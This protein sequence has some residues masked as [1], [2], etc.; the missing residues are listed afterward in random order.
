MITRPPTS[1]RLHD[2]TH[3]FKY[4][5]A[6][7]AKIILANRTL[8]WS[9]PIHF[10]DIFDV[11]REVAPNIP[12]ESISQ[13]VTNSLFCMIEQSGL[14]TSLSEQQRQQFRHDFDDEV[15]HCPTELQSLDVTLAILRQQWREAIPAMRI[16]C[17]C[18]RNDIPTMWAH[19]TDQHRGVVLRFE[20]SEFHD[21]PWLLARPVKYSPSLPAFATA[22]GFAAR[23]LDGPRALFEDY[24]YLKT[25]DWAYECEW[26]VVC[27][28]CRD[29]HGTAS[30][31]GFAPSSLSEV[32]LGPRISHEDA[33][34]ITAF[35]CHD[36]NHVRAIQAKP[37]PG[38]QLTFDVI[39]RTTKGNPL[40]LSVMHQ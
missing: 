1:N 17:L 13:V 23:M 35:L 2:R 11:H 22:E 29:D 15:R 30:D 33:H 4:V 18:E 3:F 26:R 39:S 25:P 28:A 31:W 12:A 10:N 32:I 16:L 5:T 40:D 8:R 20:C 14:L 19:Y 6:A 38:S 7:T 9:S 24:C 34:D 27:S 21:S 36:L 37:G